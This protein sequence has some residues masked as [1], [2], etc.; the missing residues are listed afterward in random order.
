MQQ[1]WSNV[2]GNVKLITNVTGKC[3]I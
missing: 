2:A 3:Q 1:E